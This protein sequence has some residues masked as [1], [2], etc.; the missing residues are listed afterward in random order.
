MREDNMLLSKR[1]EATEK[2]RKVASL[3]TMISDFERMGADL[4][5][6]IAAEEERTKIRDPRRVAYSTFAMA[7]S[8][9]RCNLLASIASLNPKFDAA[10]RELGEATQQLRELQLAQS[11]APPSTPPLSA[12]TPSPLH[13]FQ[14]GEG[15]RNTGH[16][17]P[18]LT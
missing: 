11:P 13:A 17:L 2:A 18:A 14:V 4:A 1:F 9:R 8:L 7:A 15:N 10:R 16:D 3:E 5:Q 6:Q 12:I